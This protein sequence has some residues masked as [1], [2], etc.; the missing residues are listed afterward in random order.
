MGAVQQ[1]QQQQQ[2]QH[3]SCWLQTARSETFPQPTGTTSKQRL[4]SQPKILRE[5]VAPLYR[6]EPSELNNIDL[7]PQGSE[8]R[9]QRSEIRC[10]IPPTHLTGV[11]SPSN[12]PI[13]VNFSR[14]HS[15]MVLTG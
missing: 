9:G 12:E 10:H 2:Q 13:I 11:V 14:S 5:S 6:Q 3:T 7:N 8:V 15:L 4:G 1:Q